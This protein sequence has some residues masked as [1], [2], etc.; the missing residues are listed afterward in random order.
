MTVDLIIHGVPNGH[1]MWGVS[2][3]THYFSTFYIQKEEK[4]Y[5]SVE[6]R[7]SAGKSYCYYNY[8]K[9][10]GVTASDERAGSYI[11]ITLRFDYYYK[12]ILNVFHLCEI[13]YNQLLDTILNKN[14]NNVKYKVARFE[15][16]ERE[17]NEIKK[18][19]V[20]IINLSATAKDFTA[21]NDSFFNNEG[22]T[23]KAFLLDCTPENVFQ[24]LVK[25]GK[26]DISKYYPSLNEAKKVKVLEEQHANNLILKDRELQNAQKQNEDLTQQRNKLTSDLEQKNS[27]LDQ[28][29]KQIVDKDNIIKGN[30]SAIKEVGDLKKKNQALNNDLKEKIKEIERLKSDLQKYKNNR[31]VSELIKDIKEPLQQLATVVGRQSLPFHENSFPTTSQT[32]QRT[33]KQ[34]KKWDWFRNLP[35][36]KISKI[37]LLTLILGLSVFCA[38]KLHALSKNPKGTTQTSYITPTTEHSEKSE[39]RVSVG[40]TIKTD[41]LSDSIQTSNNP[42]E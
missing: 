20:S 14:G 40:E 13:V 33:D 5:M 3:D 29:N 38:Y 34:N 36:E 25:T 19:V 17:L 11:G 32:N 16:A 9:Y 23:I 7:K 18:K 1:D 35:L 6:T 28:L 10:N 27:L 42:N 39:S 37:I 22:K 12:D 8:L 15:D 24:A 4:E 2:D 21:I 30:E 41:S 26:V 31:N